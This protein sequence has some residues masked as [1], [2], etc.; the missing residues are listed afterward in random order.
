AATTGLVLAPRG[1]S[2]MIAMIIVGRLLGRGTDPRP[3]IVL[4]LLLLAISLAE[5]MGFTSA[6]G[7]REVIH[8]GVIQGLGLGFVIVPLTTISFSTLAPWMRTEAAGVFNLLRHL[9]SSIGISVVF[10]ALARN[11]QV[12]HSMLVEN[13]T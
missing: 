4:G 5:M 9:G 11:I 3:L 6:I 10:T 7:P 13:V 12:N 8:A 2:T 1:V